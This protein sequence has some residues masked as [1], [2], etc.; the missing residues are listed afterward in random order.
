MRRYPSADLRDFINALRYWL[1]LDPIDM[2]PHP[3]RRA[4]RVIQS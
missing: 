1:N 4:T 3:K 2:G